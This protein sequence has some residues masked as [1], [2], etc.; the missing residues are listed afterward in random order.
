MVEK[1][2]MLSTNGGLERETLAPIIEFV[3]FILLIVQLFCKIEFEII[4]LFIVVFSPID[5]CGPTIEFS[6][7]TPSPIKQGSI[8]IELMF[9]ICC[10]TGSFVFSESF[11]KTC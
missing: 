6:I 2:P 3:M 8:I 10:R 5:A 7:L 4:L 11:I 1:S 9:I